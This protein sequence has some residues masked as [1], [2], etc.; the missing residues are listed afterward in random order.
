VRFALLLMV[1]CSTEI[2]HGLDEAAAN[3]MVL[4]LHRAGIR[5]DKQPDPAEASRFSVS[6][7]GKQLGRALE[8]LRSEGLPGAPQDGMGEVFAEASLI[9]T[10]TEERARY[11]RAVAGELARSIEGLHGV[12]DARVHLAIPTRDPLAPDEAVPSR[13]RASV[14]IHVNGQTPPERDVRAL[15]AG[16]VEGLLPSDVTVVVARHAVARSTVRPDRRVG[17][18]LVLASV[19]IAALAVA[20][21][22]SIQHA[23]SLRRRIAAGRG[24]GRTP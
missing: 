22:H 3:R 7:P 9:P 6:V 18:G 20:L 21:L 17:P 14:L 13:P 2:E 8:A 11:E 1:S 24:P 19:L 10:P 23:R 12:L 15:V 4:A 16:A 5:A